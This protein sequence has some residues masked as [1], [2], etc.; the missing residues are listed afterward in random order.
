M[1]NRRKW[2]RMSVLASLSVVLLCKYQNCAQP[3]QMNAALDSAGGTKPLPVSTIDPVRAHS[4][5][6]FEK[7][8]VELPAD[9]TPV[10]IHG[11]C[12]EEQSGAILRWELK[13]ANQE[14]LGEGYAECDNGAFHVEF[15]PGQIA[16]LQC[17]ESYRLSA[18]L[19]LGSP[20]EVEILGDCGDANFAQVQ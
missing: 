15:A 5:V 19:G 2:V 20:G 4:D 11:F 14:E 10:A 16:E 7:E 8:R 9:G 1:I 18:Q 17:G 3:L 12:D 13:N 6:G